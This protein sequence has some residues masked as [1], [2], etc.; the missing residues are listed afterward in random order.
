MATKS[1]LKDVNIKEKNMGR[2]FVTA[3]EQSSTYTSARKV[4]N[5][6]FKSISKEDIKKLFGE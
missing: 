6:K 2:A 3:L 5:S 4:S 1:I